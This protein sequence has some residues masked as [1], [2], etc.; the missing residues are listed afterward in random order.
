MSSPQ[1]G[2]GG[3]TT[4]CKHAV[5][6]CIAT[7]CALVASARVSGCLS[8]QQAR[9]GRRQTHGCNGVPLW[10]SKSRTTGSPPLFPCGALPAAAGC[11]RWPNAPSTA[12]SP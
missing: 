4:A 7:G 10:R 11:H 1:C 9:G 2:H 5:R 8:R 6:V 12:P 3:H